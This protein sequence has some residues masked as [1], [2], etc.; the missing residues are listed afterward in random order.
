MNNPAETAVSVDLAAARFRAGVARRQ[1]RVISYEYPLLVVGIAAVEPD[2]TASEHAFRFELTGFPGTAPHALIWD[3]T[4]SA[5][6]PV[7]RR[8]KGSARVIEAFKDWTAPHPVYRPWERISGQ[9]NNFAQAHP[10][11][12]WHAKRDLAFILEDL[13][14]LLSSNAAGRSTGQAA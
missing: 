1:W 13:Y 8:P 4:A 11:L 5:H 3:A 6:L 10:D 14:G 9:H 2:G 12:A 7:S